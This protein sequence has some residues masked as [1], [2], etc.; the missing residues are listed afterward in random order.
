V[1]SIY[2]TKKRKKMQLFEKDSRV[3][4]V[5]EEDYERY[6]EF[7][8]ENTKYPLDEDLP[9]MELPFKLRG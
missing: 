1:F 9:K 8:K 5:L 7:V 4:E 6:S 2:Y 3:R